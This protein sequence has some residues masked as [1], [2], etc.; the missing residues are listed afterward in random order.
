MSQTTTTNTRPTLQTRRASLPP[1]T[2][3]PPR[4][5]H[6]AY[7]LGRYSLCLLASSQP[8]LQHSSVTASYGRFYLSPGLQVHFVKRKKYKQESQQA[9]RHRYDTR[10]HVW[11]QALALWEASARTPYRHRLRRRRPS[12]QQAT[13]QPDIRRVEPL[14]PFTRFTL[15]RREC[16]PVVSR[17][18]PEGLQ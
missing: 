18:A 4:T 9:L 1:T 17:A 3:S 16:R 5:L 12:A 13:R 15:N 10:R 2:I 8:T 14:H 7:A 6:V 11:S